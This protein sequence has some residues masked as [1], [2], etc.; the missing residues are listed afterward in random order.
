MR[1]ICAERNVIKN[2][3]YSLDNVDNIEMLIR[4]I[5]FLPK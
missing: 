5:Q 1:Y 4:I 2:H 3:L